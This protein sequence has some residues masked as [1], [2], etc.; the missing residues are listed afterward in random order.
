MDTLLL[1]YTIEPRGERAFI[2]LVPILRR[3]DGR[4]M[5]LRAYARLSD[6]APVLEASANFLGTLR[7]AVLS[8]GHQVNLLAAAG[9]LGQLQR[10]GSEL[11]S[12]LLPDEIISLLQEEGQVRH[13]TFCYDPRLNAVPFDCVPLNG[14]FLGFQFAVGRELLSAGTAASRGAGR[15]AG[16]PLSGRF[17]L[18]PPPELSTTERAEVIRQA[19][20]F[21]A[22]WGR[23]GRN[24]SIRFDSLSLTGA[25]TAKDVLEAFQT[26]EIVSVYSHHFYDENHPE[27]SGY[28]L[29]GQTMFT[30]RQLLDGF[31]AGQMSPLLV[32]SLSC[33]SG[34]TRGWENDWPKSERLY[35]MVDAAKR[36]GVLHYIGTL[37][38][39]PAPKSIGLFGPFYGALADGFTIGEALRLTRLSLRR[40]PRDPEDG[41]TVLGLALTLYGDP[42]VALL[43][44]SGHRTAEVYAPV[45]EG[46]TG[47]ALCG[48][49]VAPQDPGYALRLCPDHYSPEGCSAGHILS[50]GTSL[51]KCCKCDNKLCP[52]CAGWGRQLCWEHCCFEGH[53]IVAGVKKVCS[54]PQR[55]HPGEKRSICPFDEARWL[56]GLCRECFPASTA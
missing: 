17:I 44:R 16:I 51:K 6:L 3:N 7:S 33:E 37:V 2:G 27:T 42:S 53:E 19:V 39:I 52:Q 49:A 24:I 13:V 36:I 29:G 22:E 34:I 12:R 45:C 23:K 15:P 41:G 21:Y 20:D 50:S 35:G 18:V 46:K 38:E 55:R 30:A 5:F 28:R 54:D 32:F 31:A 11:L 47:G 1:H 56:R 4:L 43:S 14:D 8:M 25:P 10:H 48:K 40:N 9:F 26:R